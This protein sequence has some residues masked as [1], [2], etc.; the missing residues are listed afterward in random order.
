MKEK[1]YELV[2]EL[3]T[4]G[5]HHGTTTNI[6]ARMVILDDVDVTV[7]AETV[8][9]NRNTLYRK[10]RRIREVHERIQEV[11]CEGD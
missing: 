10:V 1:E 3:T 8:G 7:A 11:Y 2:R 5:Q 9:I 6:A 4:R